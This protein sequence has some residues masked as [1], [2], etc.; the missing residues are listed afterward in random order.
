MS[1]T[2]TYYDSSDVPT[3]HFIHENARGVC[4]MSDLRRLET[5]YLEQNRRE[6]ELTKHIS[7]VLLDPLAFVQLRETGRC[8]IN[9]P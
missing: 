2:D 8:F 7:L 1:T 5:A 9:L 6:F 4:G 3:R